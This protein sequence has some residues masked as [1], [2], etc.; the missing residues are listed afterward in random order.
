MGHEH[1]MELLRMDILTFRRERVIDDLRVQDLHVPLGEVSRL[2]V[3]ALERLR[4]LGE[5]F[6]WQSLAPRRRTKMDE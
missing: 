2:A 1:A 4:V 3:H 6:G 5:H